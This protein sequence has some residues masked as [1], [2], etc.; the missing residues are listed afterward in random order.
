[1]LNVA[2]EGDSGDQLCHV[3]TPGESSAFVAVM[4]HV[5]FLVE[6][7]SKDL[8]REKCLALVNFFMS[9]NIYVK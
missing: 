9:Q 2:I 3:C 5:E 8:V 6:P 4:L 1:M 7:G